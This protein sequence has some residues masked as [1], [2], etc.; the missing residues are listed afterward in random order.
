MRTVKQ[1]IDR[2]SNAI[3]QEDFMGEF[4]AGHLSDMLLRELE[5]AWHVIPDSTRGIL[6]GV[7]TE[8]K[9]H[10]NYSTVAGIAASELICR[11]QSQK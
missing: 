8:L 9:R 1:T 10:H 2:V 6:V 5:T 4:D 3:M 7:G 11:M